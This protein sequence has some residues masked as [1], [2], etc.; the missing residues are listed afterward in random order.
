MQDVR[1]KKQFKTTGAWPKKQR[2][3]DWTIANN[4]CSLPKFEKWERKL[5][6]KLMNKR[7]NLLKNYSCSAMKCL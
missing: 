2:K 4:S 6:D 1:A 7:R 3:I 5:V